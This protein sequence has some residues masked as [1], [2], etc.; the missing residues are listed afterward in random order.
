MKVGKLVLLLEDAW[1]APGAQIYFTMQWEF[2][3]AAAHR[4]EG[5]GCFT[6]RLVPLGR[7]VLLLLSHHPHF[8]NQTHI[9]NSSIPS[10]KHQHKTIPSLKL[11]LD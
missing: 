4:R 10:N 1:L 2:N 9:L 8:S 3:G 5:T 7:R 6:Y 11:G